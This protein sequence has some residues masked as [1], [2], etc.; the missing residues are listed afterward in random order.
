MLKEYRVHGLHCKNCS[1]QLDDDIKSL[2]N[3]EGIHYN[4]EEGILSFTD[5]D[6]LE[7]VKILVRANGGILLE[8]DKKSQHKDKRHYEQEDNHSHSHVSTGD[9]SSRNIGIAFFLNL[10]F[11]IAEFIFGS[12]FNSFAIMSDAVHDLGDAF[13]IGVSWILQKV[14][15]KEPDYK[16]ADGYGRF[17]LLGSLFTGLVLIGGSITMVILSIPRMFSPEPVNYKGMFWL[18]IAAIAINGYAGYLMYK[19]AS[20]NERMLSF[21]M[22]E[23]ILGWVAVLVVSFVLRFVDWYIL[24]PIL[25][26]LIASFIL[27]KTIPEFISSAKVFM[28]VAPHNVDMAELKEKILDLNHVHGISNLHTHSIDG[29]SNVFSATL[30]VNTK[31]GEKIEEIKE[32]ARLLLINYNI[33]NTTI[34]VVPDIKR[35]VTYRKT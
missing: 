33:V 19:G 3:S 27:Y 1:D 17:S 10:F 11:S 4:K 34:E 30:F 32:Q 7:D 31:D 5:E 12:L 9:E 18:A 28:N 2:P 13:S 22:L 23:D 25:S 26:F 14:S 21:H 24:D 20:K 15:T 29:V 16:Y 8:G 6:D 35:I